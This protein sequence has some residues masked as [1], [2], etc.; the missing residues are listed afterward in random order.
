MD[1]AP[2]HMHVVPAQGTFSG[3][4]RAMNPLRIRSESGQSA[5]EF[6]IILPLVIVVILA[7]A[8]FG[9]ALFMYLEAEHAASDAARV[10]AVDTTPPAGTTLQNYLKQQ[11]VFGEL[12][13][14]SGKTSGAQGV[15]KLC[16]NLPE[17]TDR[18]DPV[19]VKVTNTFNWV[20]GGVIPGSVTI[21]GSATMRI[22]QVP[23]YSVGCST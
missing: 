1:P 7:L 17:G 22:E 20:P 3:K 14:G 8:D 18:G 13:T 23:S 11:L 15:A 19:N 2:S 21:A 16:I 6:A 4:F 10:A 12:G 5:V 9:R